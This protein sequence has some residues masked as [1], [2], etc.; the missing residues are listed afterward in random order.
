M[1]RSRSDTP[2]AA[3]ASIGDCWN[4][5]YPHGRGL[6]ADASGCHPRNTAA[7]AGTA[8]VAHTALVARRAAAIGSANPARTGR[9]GC[10]AGINQ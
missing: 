3:D 7:I 2:G 4:G 5:R 10:A 9:I 8:L 1:L 6:R